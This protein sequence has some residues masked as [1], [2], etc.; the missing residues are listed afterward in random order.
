MTSFATSELMKLRLLTRDESVFARNKS[1]LARYP[2]NASCTKE[3]TW[4]ASCVLLQV[5]L[6][7]HAQHSQLRQIYIDLSLQLKVNT[8]S[9]GMALSIKRGKFCTN[10]TLNFPQ[11]VFLDYFMITY[12]R[13]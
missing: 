3:F 7:S 12:T 10:V 2:R 8:T 9:I 4:N 1:C 11:N 5:Q 6:A 13:C